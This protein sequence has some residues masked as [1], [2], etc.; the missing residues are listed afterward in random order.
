[1]IYLDAVDDRKG[2]IE[3]HKQDPLRNIEIKREASTP[4]TLEEYIANTKRDSPNITE[5][6]SELWDVE[7]SHQAKLAEE[8]VFV[9]KMP[10]FARKMLVENLIHRYIPKRLDAKI[11]TLSFYALGIHKLSNAYTEEQKASF[12]QF[13]LNVRNPFYMSLI[14]EFQDRFPHGKTVVIPDGH[15]FCFISEEEL[16]YDEMRKFLL[17]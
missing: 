13:F 11:P 17:E 5:I 7:M 15:H 1:M 12:T 2:L 3:I 4:H 9:D 10:E 8:G 16:V 14:S 6:W